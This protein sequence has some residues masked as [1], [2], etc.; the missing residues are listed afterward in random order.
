MKTSGSS[1]VVDR[2]SWAW[3][4]D[5]CRCPLEGFKQ[6][7]SVWVLCQCQL[8]VT[9]SAPQGQRPT[10]D[11]WLITP[12]PRSRRNAK[13]DLE[14]YTA[15][16]C[17]EKM[18]FRVSIEICLCLLPSICLSHTTEALTL[19]R[20]KKVIFFRSK[21][22]GHSSSMYIHWLWLHNT[23]IRNHKYFAVC[24]LGWFLYFCV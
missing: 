14:D 15:R 9:E 24:F 23:N 5:I 10:A 8:A 6:L 21:C 1:H 7:V 16:Y 2:K 18:N 19:R 12:W 13:W 11:L 22:Y 17:Q 20:I 4:N 3:W